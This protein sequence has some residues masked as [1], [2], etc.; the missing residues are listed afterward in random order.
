[1]FKYLILM[2]LV[3]LSSDLFADSYFYKD[4][5][6]YYSNQLNLL[7]AKEI[8]VKRTLYD[9]Y[10]NEK[11]TRKSLLNKLNEVDIKLEEDKEKIA[12]SVYSFNDYE[13]YNN[14]E[15]DYQTASLDFD[16]KNAFYHGLWHLDY[17]KSNPKDYVNVRMAL[18]D[19]Y[20]SSNRL[21]PNLIVENCLDS[22]NVSC[23][24]GLDMTN[25][26]NNNIFKN[27]DDHT[28]WLASIINGHNCGN[29]KSE[30]KQIGVN[31]KAK[32]LITNVS[33]SKN[34]ENLH[35]LNKTID[36]IYELDNNDINVIYIPLAFNKYTKKQKESLQI[37]VNIYLSKPNRAIVSVVGNSNNVSKRDEPLPCII[38]GVICVGGLDRNGTIWKGTASLDKYIDVY[39][40]ASNIIGGITKKKSRLE[41]SGVS[42]AGA[43]VAAE[44]SKV[45]KDE[46]YKEKID[47]IKKGSK[48]IL[49]KDGTID[50]SKKGI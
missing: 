20:L 46:N 18:I 6:I 21:L 17:I 42:A 1:M 7:K 40:P 28:Y 16:T 12:K 34:N 13:L 41:E 14:E 32:L 2:I 36:A 23:K 11:I 26:L 15:C 33:I 29:N 9:Y 4:K 25:K 8:N 48:F 27:N 31:P 10:K 50:K 45:I 44:I 5:E 30:I 47:K 3:L 24:K 22:N 35:S 37:A 38:D 49:N 39:A 19:G 43:I